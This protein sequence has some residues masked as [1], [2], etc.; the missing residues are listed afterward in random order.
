MEVDHQTTEN[1]G[2]AISVQYSV[3]SPACS[4]SI[5]KQ[6]R[7]DAHWESLPKMHSK[8]AKFAAAVHDN[9]IY[10]FGG[11]T[12][13]HENK[14][15][16]GKGYKTNLAE[17]YDPKTNTWTKLPRMIYSRSECSSAVVG[18]NIYVIG[19]DANSV[20]RKSEVFNTRTKTW[21]V[22]PE[23]P[24]SKRKHNSVAVG[25]KIYVFG[26]VK[27]NSME[28]YDTVTNSWSVMEGKFDTLRYSFA[29]A[30]IGNK[31]Y[32][33]GGM[34]E[35][36]H[37]NASCYSR[38]LETMEVYDIEQDEWTV[39]KSMSN[40]RCGCSAVVV[41]S[42]IVV[43]G[44]LD[45]KGCVTSIE[46]FDIAKQEWAG[47]CIAPS[48]VQ[49]KLFSA[50]MLRE[51]NDLVV[52]GGR[53]ESN[54]I[55]GSVEKCS[56]LGALENNS[57]IPSINQCTNIDPNEQRLCS[58]RLHIG[59]GAKRKSECV[60]SLS[61]QRSIQGSVS[62]TKRGSGDTNFPFKNSK[63]A[64]IFEGKLYSGH[65]ESFDDEEGF[66]SVVYEDGDREELDFTELNLA[67]RHYKEEVLAK[68]EVRDVTTNSNRVKLEEFNH[69]TESASELASQT[70]EPQ[71]SKIVLGSELCR[72]QEM[73]GAKR[74]EV[75]KLEEARFGEVQRGP[76]ENRIERLK[77]CVLKDMEKDFFGNVQSG[78]YQERLKK[79]KSRLDNNPNSL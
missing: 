73:I 12:Y 18:D 26:G 69:V 13:M 2:D 74:R 38:Y 41:G 75:C 17:M 50:L 48:R 51:Q 58:S 22:L 32:A 7:I 31:I 30:T 34:R 10:V 62:S 70:V 77:L 19:G 11:T 29:T 43:L 37:N 40:R 60:M 21:N 3:V 53:D 27:T 25:T 9:K 63:I 24:R 28:V 52:M 67:M 14:V 16:S 36:R 55:L 1:S 44:G 42:T 20:S 8:R 49:R 46:S 72:L 4:D 65:V 15:H 64:K 76:V 5:V 6:E 79:L 33:I 23:M 47:S 71:G 56:I 59:K 39:S 45:E 54:Y 68:R 61:S 78:D 57:V 35:L 66:F